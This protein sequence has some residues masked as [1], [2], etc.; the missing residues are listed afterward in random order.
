[1]VEHYIKLE[2][3]PQQWLL[4][5]LLGRLQSNR[6]KKE[7]RAICDMSNSDEL[8]Y[9]D[10]TTLIPP[11]HPNILLHVYTRRQPTPSLLSV[12]IKR[13]A[14]I[15]IIPAIEPSL[16]EC[17]RIAAINLDDYRNVPVTPPPSPLSPL[18]M[19]GYRRMIV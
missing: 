14:R 18:S 6:K 11:K 19:A 9:S 5:P 10:N 7:A 1:M 16:A 15:S 2:K 4:T 17:A 13:T 8:R 12:P 3:K